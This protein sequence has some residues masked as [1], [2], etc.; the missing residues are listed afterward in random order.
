MAENKKIKVSFIVEIVLYSVFGLIGIWGL[1]YIILGS[2]VDSNAVAY[3]SGLADAN[4]SIGGTIG[5][6][7]LA[8]GL[9][10]LGLAILAS[11]ITLLIFAK[12]SD[13]EFEKEQRRILARQNRRKGLANQEEVVEAEVE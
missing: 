11:V 5:F 7:F 8:Q 10:I 1:V 9:L 4:K 12:S 3:N 13:R 2:L 6:G